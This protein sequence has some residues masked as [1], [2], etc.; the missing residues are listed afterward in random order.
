MLK[1]KRLF[2]GH[3]EVVGHS[4]PSLNA[5]IWIYKSMTGNYW[6]CSYTTGCYQKLSDAKADCFAHL[7]ADG[8]ID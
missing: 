4:W 8:L 1:L 7:K 2:A 6:T 5:G 3:Y